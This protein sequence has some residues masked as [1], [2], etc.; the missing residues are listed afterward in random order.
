MLFEKSNQKI[1][2]FLPDLCFQNGVDQ[3]FCSSRFPGATSFICFQL[4]V[5]QFNQPFACLAESFHLALCDDA[6]DKQFSQLRSFSMPTQ[7][8]AS[9]ARGQIVFD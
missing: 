6:Q 4:S 1:S 5:S 2:L 8:I 3:T 9:R 7:P